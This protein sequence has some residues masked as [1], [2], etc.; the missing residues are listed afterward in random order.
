MTK[1]AFI[2]VLKN[3]NPQEMMDYLLH[4]GKKP[5]PFNPFRMLSTKELEEIRN[6]TDN[7]RINGGD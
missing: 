3:N 6:G 2:A 1:E 5:K 7:E 4:N